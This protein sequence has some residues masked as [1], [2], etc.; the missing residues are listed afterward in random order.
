MTSMSPHIQRLIAL[1][2]GLNSRFASLLNGKAPAHLRALLDDLE[3]HGQLCHRS[4]AIGKSSGLGPASAGTAALRSLLIDRV[5]PELFDI[6]DGVARPDRA[7]TGLPASRMGRMSA[8]DAGETLSAI[9]RWERLAFSTALTAQRQQ[10]VARLLYSRIAADAASVSEKL[11]MPDQAELGKAALLIFRIETPGLVLDSLGQPQMVVE[12][13]RISRRIARLAMRSVSR[14]IRQYLASREMVAHF[15]VSSILS[16]I[17]DLLLILLRILEGENEELKEG[18]GHPFIVSLG[19]DTLDVFMADA[20]ALL[21]HYMMIAQ[22]A[23]TN[24]SVSSAV[25]E[26]FGRHIQTLLRLLDSFTRTGGPHRFRVMAQRTRV[27]IDEM[28]KDIDQTS[29][30]AKTAEKIALLR[31]YIASR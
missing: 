19:Q 13:K 6:L 5:L 10:E 9:A 8:V 28:L 3:H 16:E 27:R 20:E 4:S 12:L 14:T 11:D 23:L 31:P 29:P 17:D 18:A 1:Q 24:E 30:Q 26:I 25:V 7:G 2:D 15:D 22:R 21:D